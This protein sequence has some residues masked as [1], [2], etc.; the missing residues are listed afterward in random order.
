MRWD[1]A[2]GNTTIYINGGDDL[3]ADMAITLQG[4]VNLHAGDFLLT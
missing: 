3:S 1:S 2:G 4:V